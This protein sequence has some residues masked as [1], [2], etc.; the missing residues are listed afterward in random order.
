MFIARVTIEPKTKN[1]F[2]RI[3]EGA[4][5]EQR[6]FANLQSYDTSGAEIESRCAGIIGGAQAL[7][8]FDVFGHD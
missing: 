5:K 3:A 8:G 6:F 2:R 4:R 7:D 1:P